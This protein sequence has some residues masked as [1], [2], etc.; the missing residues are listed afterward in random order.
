VFYCRGVKQNILYSR[1]NTVEES[2]GFVKQWNASHIWSE[3]LERAFTAAMSKSKE[4][5]IYRD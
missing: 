2:L 1:D 4:G 5:P 3:D